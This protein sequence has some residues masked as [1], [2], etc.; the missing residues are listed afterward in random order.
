VFISGWDALTLAANA[1]SFGAL[2][3]VV[4]KLPNK[5][6]TIVYFCLLASYYGGAL[7]SG[8]PRMQESLQ[9]YAV[10]MESVAQPLSF[11]FYPVI[12]LECVFNSTTFSYAP[13]VGFASNVLI[14]LTLAIILIN[15]REFSY[16]Q[17]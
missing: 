8:T 12:D 15:R 2:G 9:G 17:D 14:Y 10:P 6:S 11:A 1:L 7:N 3:L 16:A 13:L 5:W 4:A